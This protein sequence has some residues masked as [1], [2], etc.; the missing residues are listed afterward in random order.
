[1]RPGMDHMDGLDHHFTF[2]KIC[3]YYQCHSWNSSLS[4]T[5]DKTTPRVLAQVKMRN[6]E[7]H[8]GEL[9]HQLVSL[10]M[11]GQDQRLVPE[12]S[13]T[14]Q[15]ARRTSLEDLMSI[16][17]GKNPGSYTI[18]C[19]SEQLERQS[20]KMETMRLPDSIDISVSEKLG[21]E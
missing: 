4:I 1:M 15:H 16:H 2:K 9:Y 20:S 7:L 6:L 11:W 10:A 5:Q 18:D 21:V 17:H 12:S 14:G 13:R 8:E 3:P 19:F